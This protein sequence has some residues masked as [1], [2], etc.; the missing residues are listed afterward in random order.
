[1][2][3]RS[4]IPI[5]LPALLLAISPARAGSA[6]DRFEPPVPIAVNG[7]PLEL[8]DPGAYPELGDWDGDGRR[9][10]LVG[11]NHGRLRVFHNLGTDHEPEFSQPVW[12]DELIAD[13]RIP[14]G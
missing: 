8:S 3:T 5:L 7:R 11:Q 10:L 13:G 6:A 14:E 4:T 1:M 12:F 9:D 2:T